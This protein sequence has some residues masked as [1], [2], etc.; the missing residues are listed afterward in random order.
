MFV[1]YGLL[2]TALGRSIHK[3]KHKGSIYLLLLSSLLWTLFRGSGPEAPN[4]AG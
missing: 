2:I 3:L 4:A 1:F